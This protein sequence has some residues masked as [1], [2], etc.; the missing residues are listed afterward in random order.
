MKLHLW[1]SWLLP[2]FVYLLLAN[3]AA[4]WAV[5][6]TAAELEQHRQSIGRL[7][8]ELSSHLEKIEQTGEKETNLL[9]ELEQ[10]DRKLS[11]QKK[12]LATITTQLKEQE[13]LLAQKEQ[14]LRKAWTIRNAVRTH[15]QKRLR[16]YYLVGRITLLDVTFSN[17][18]LPDLMVFGDSFRLLLEYDRELMARYRDTIEELRRARDAEQLEKSVLKNFLAQ[19]VKEKDK[20]SRLRQEKEQL[21]SRIRTEQSL[22]TQA[23]REMRR[24]EQQLSQTL[25]R[26]KQQQENRTRGFVLNRGRLDPPVQGRL[27]RRFGERRDN[28]PESV[29]QSQ[30]ISI[31]TPE[32]APV[33]A[34]YKGKVLFA[35]YMRGYG[36]MVIIDHGLRY[37]TVTARLDQ[38]LVREGQQV[39]TGRQ[40]GITGDIATL[41]DQGLYFEIRHGAR[42]EDPL[43]WFKPGCLKH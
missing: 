21:L 5:A 28:D 41:F 12:T 4:G 42:T 2:G 11:Q 19:A 13:K 30:G 33:R 37:Y 6:R 7:R 22:Y 14:E 18:K 20:L 35:G 43:P 25:T 38:I 31:E 17:Q 36:N 34:I 40:I 16:A 39:E 1:K 15:L 3:G 32:N 24:A 23:V 27:I 9:E 26:L 29:D 8:S 10:I